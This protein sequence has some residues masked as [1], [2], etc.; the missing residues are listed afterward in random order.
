MK[1]L[2]IITLFFAVTSCVSVPKSTQNDILE[3]KKMV[4]TL[5]GDVKN[6][7]IKSETQISKLDENY[8]NI[9]K[10]IVKPSNVATNYDNLTSNQLDSL[11]A[12]RGLIKKD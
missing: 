10:G 6:H 4:Q 5:Q 2:I 1:K 7:S 9:L 11:R 12:V 8:Q 3:I